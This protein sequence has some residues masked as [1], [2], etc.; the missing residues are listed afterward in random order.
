MEIKIAGVSQFFFFAIPLVLAVGATA[1][2]TFFDGA[3]QLQRAWSQEKRHA[4]FVGAPRPIKAPLKIIAE[5]ARD[6]RV[7]VDHAEI[8]GGDLWIYYKNVSA[9]RVASIRFNWKEASP[10]GTVVAF[11]EGYPSIYG[12]SHSPDELDPGERAELHLKIK[13]DPR[14]ATMTIWM[15]CSNL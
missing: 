7:I 6:A 15:E 12:E 9:S 13:S 2:L 8:N 11:G 1:W 3:H 5:P 14:A 4:E 10:D